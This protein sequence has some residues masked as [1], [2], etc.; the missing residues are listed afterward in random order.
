MVAC[1]RPLEWPTLPLP[2]TVM[3]FVGIIDER[4]CEADIACLAVGSA[5]QG[6]G[7]CLN[8]DGEEA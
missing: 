3:L 1:L 5:V 6:L 4:D 2:F 7:A 8:E